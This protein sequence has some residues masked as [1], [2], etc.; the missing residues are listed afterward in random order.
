MKRKKGSGVSPELSSSGYQPEIIDLYDSNS[1]LSLTVNLVGTKKEVLEVG[2]STGYLTKLLKARHNHVTCIEI[3]KESAEIA[4]EHC[5][6]MIVGDIESLDLDSSLKPG[7]FDV[8]I[9]GDVLEHLRWPGSVLQKIKKYLKP[10]AFIIASIP[11]IGHGDV[12]LNLMSQKFTYTPIGLIDSTHLRFFTLPGVRDL[13]DTSGYKVCK[14]MTTKMDIGETEQGETTRSIPIP[15]KSFVEKIP[16]SNVYQFVVT[17][18]LKENKKVSE[19]TWPVIDIS[20]V[21]VDGIYTL[22]SPVRKK[23]RRANLLTASG[24]QILKNEGLV[25]FSY[26]FKDYVT[27]ASRKK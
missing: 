2:P 1:S 25:G 22:L 26:R 11:N 23:W 21:S 13:F 3:D 6:R 19:I 27:R 10:D 4:K 24:L 17:A 16:F 9:F 20:E 8:I 14:L 15:I 5:D 18:Y 12:I 7:Q